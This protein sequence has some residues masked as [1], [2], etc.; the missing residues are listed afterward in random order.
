[1]QRKIPFYIVVA[2]SLLS[3]QSLRF[4]LA[5]GVFTATSGIRLDDYRF[6]E[7]LSG[8]GSVQYSRSTEPDAFKIRIDHLSWFLSIGAINCAALT[9]LQQLE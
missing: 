1:M 2:R 3:P 4:K 9:I 5:R 6:Q 8:N 7:S